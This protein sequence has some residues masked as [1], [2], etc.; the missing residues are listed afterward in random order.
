MDE[1]QDRPILDVEGFDAQ[2]HALLYGKS[3]K[4]T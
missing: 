2:R 4:S 3:D 1:I